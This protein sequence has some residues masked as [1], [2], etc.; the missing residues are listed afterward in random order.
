MYRIL[1]R[2]FRLELQNGL[3]FSFIIKFVNF[4]IPS[5][6]FHFAYLLVYDIG[7]YYRLIVLVLLDNGEAF[8]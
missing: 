1:S 5:Y 2:L 7:Y 8:L 4:W 6:K 3:F